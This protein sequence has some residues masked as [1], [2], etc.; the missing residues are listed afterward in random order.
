MQS[1]NNLIVREVPSWKLKVGEYVAS[2]FTQWQR[3]ALFSL[4]FLDVVILGLL[5]FVFVNYVSGI[6]RETALQSELASPST[7]D[8]AGYRARHQVLGLRVDLVQAIPTQPGMYDFIAIINNPNTLWAA[9]DVEVQFRNGSFLFSPVR[10][11]VMPGEQRAVALFRQSVPSGLS[12]PSAALT[13]AQWKKV[14]RVVV[15]SAGIEYRAVHYTPLDGDTT[16]LDFEVS[17][18]TPYSFWRV[19]LMVMA[20]DNDTIVGAFHT[21]VERLRS[22]EA[23]TVALAWQYALPSVTRTTVDVQLN[24]ADPSILMEPSGTLQSPF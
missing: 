10:T 14:K 19:P 12:T 23:R 15:S 3:T 22:G 18:L 24:V 4:F 6:P 9:L 2:H 13:K 5:A 8:Y 17:N 21:V 1:S 20:W 7:I 16:G 11:Y